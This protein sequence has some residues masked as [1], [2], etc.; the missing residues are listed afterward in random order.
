[1]MIEGFVGFIG[2]G[3]IGR[4]PLFVIIMTL[5]AFIAAT[6]TDLKRREVPDTL[7]FTYLGAG[8]AYSI[9]L[10]L[11]V[12]NYFALINAAAGI[13]IAYGIG[14]I[15]YYTGQWGGGDTKLLLGFGAWHGLF[16]NSI[17]LQFQEL[18]LLHFVIALFA[19]G[20]AYGLF[21]LVFLIVK[22]KNKIITAQQKNPGIKM[23]LLL[24][25]SLILILLGLMLPYP[26]NILSLMLAISLSLLYLLMKHSKGIEEAL[27]IKDIPVEKLTEGDWLAEDV[28]IGK[29]TIAK[30]SG[31]GLSKEDITEIRKYHSKGRI[32]KVRIKEGIP[33]IPAFLIGY[34]ILLIL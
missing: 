7:N 1:M 12:N 11:A 27:F 22:S 6:L 5:I 32:D 30:K 16:Y 26:L 21:Y 4:V 20:G 10:S 13:A 23:I 3:I 2:G 29:K 31:E 33:F 8:I 34:I 24:F 28:V 14:A 15:L 19:A 9:I 17:A 25:F 18:L